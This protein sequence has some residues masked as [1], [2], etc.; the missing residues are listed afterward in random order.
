MHSRYQFSFVSARTSLVVGALWNSNPV[1]CIQGKQSCSRLRSFHPLPLAL[2][3]G[4]TSAP[5][6]WNGRRENSPIHFPKEIFSIFLYTVQV[7]FE[8]YIPW[9]HIKFSF[10][11]ITADN[12]F[13]STPAP[14]TLPYLCLLRTLHRT[15]LSNYR[16][17]NIGIWKKPQTQK[18]RK[19]IAQGLQ[20]ID[21]LILDWLAW[22]SL[23]HIESHP[24]ASPVSTFPAT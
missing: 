18:Q 1:H 9:V 4:T 13:P 5:P 10:I 15:R 19:L 3:R 24:P 6:F 16:F 21:C 2:R 11:E 14:R 23:Q 22:Q 17:F 7:A 12:Q 20:S 8:P